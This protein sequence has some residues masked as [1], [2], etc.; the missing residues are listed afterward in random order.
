[1]FFATL[2][3]WTDV[4][5]MTQDAHSETFS[6]IYFLLVVIVGSFF[7]LNVALAV[8]WEAFQELS[9]QREMLDLESEGEESNVDPEDSTMVY[10]FFFL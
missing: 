7:L 5:Y 2:E 8:V 10:F 6:F 9:T 3:G 1:M 4:M